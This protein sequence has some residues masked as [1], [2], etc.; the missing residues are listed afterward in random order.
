[1][2]GYH[3]CS[4]PAITNSPRVMV[5]RP[6]RG[7]AM[8]LFPWSTC[9]PSMT[10]HY[11]SFFGVVLGTAHEKISPSPFVPCT[12]SC[13]CAFMSEQISKMCKNVTDERWCDNLFWQEPLSILIF[14]FTP[15]TTLALL[16]NRNFK[17]LQIW[18]A[19]YIHKRSKVKGQLRLAVWS[20]HQNNLQT[21]QKMLSDFTQHYLV[22]WHGHSAPYGYMQ[23]WDIETE[24][25]VELWTR[26][27]VKAC[28]HLA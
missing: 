18:R 6:L 1:M 4:W 7:W 9:I 22:R 17:C 10:F 23:C 24:G 12:E 19:F 27:G 11:M 26:G 16:G 20:T 25:F 8:P 3:A 14:M 21:I 28:W 5:A 2:L 13:C 15:T